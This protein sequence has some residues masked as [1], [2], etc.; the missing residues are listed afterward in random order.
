[1]IANKY[2]KFLLLVITVLGVLFLLKNPG[3]FGSYVE[4]VDRTDHRAVA[5]NFVTKNGFIAKRIGKIDRHSYFADGGGG[6]KTSY[7]VFRLY[8]KDKTG[9][10]ELTI[11]KN[12]KGEW[13]VTSALLT[14]E[15]TE[16][17]IPIKRSGKRKLPKVL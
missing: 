7:N 15:G 12:E 13:F 11:K 3:R 1:M 17:M 5:I 10:C 16:Y 4:R 9:V 8:G 14:V 6:G 2:I